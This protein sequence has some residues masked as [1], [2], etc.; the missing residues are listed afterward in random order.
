MRFRRVTA[1]NVPIGFLSSSQKCLYFFEKCKNWLSRWSPKFFFVATKFMFC[2]NN[3]YFKLRHLE[4]NFERNRDQEWTDLH[5]KLQNRWK[6][7]NQSSFSFFSPF[8][9]VEKG[10][11]NTALNISVF[12]PKSFVCRSKIVL[13]SLASEN[14]VFHYIFVCFVSFRNGSSVGKAR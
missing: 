14:F 9:S 3:L 4:L 6:H 11:G 13:K 2:M 1:K 10:D 8:C 12:L 5:H 7:W